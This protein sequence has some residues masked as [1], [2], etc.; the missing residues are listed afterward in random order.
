MRKKKSWPKNVEAVPRESLYCYNIY[1]IIPNAAREQGYFLAVASQH[2][3][4]KLLTWLW[5][6]DSLRA[7]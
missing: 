6:E 1:S 3:R 7:A 2:A 5:A 4:G